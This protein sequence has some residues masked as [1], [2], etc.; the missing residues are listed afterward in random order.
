MS[1]EPTPG[2]DVHLQLRVRVEGVRVV[3]AGV[4]EDRR[5]RRAR[6]RDR[7]VRAPANRGLERLAGVVDAVAAPARV[8][9]VVGVAEEVVDRLD[10]GDAAAVGA[11]LGE[12][13]ARAVDRRR[14]RLVVVAD[15]PVERC[16][17]ELEGVR[18][19]AAVRIDE[20]LL[21]DRR[22]LRRRDE[23]VP[24][25][26]GAAGVAVEA[27]VVHAEVP[28]GRVEIAA[29]DAGPAGDRGG[30]RSGGGIARDGRLG[31]DAARRQRLAAHRE[32][33]VVGGQVDD[34]LARQD[35]NPVDELARAN[36]D[37]TA[38]RRRDV[39][40]GELV[41]GDAERIGV[42]SQVAD[43]CRG[44]RGAGA[45]PGGRG[46][47]STGLAGDE[48][49]LA[50]VVA[51]GHV[52]L[53]PEPLGGSGRRGEQDQPQGGGEGEDRRGEPAGGLRGRD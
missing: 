40:D 16:L 46:D 12:H 26:P 17:G 11:A 5:R 30:R 25:E 22:I 18:D 41:A 38:R 43:R 48:D 13:G 20:D 35:R 32:D 28:G 51:A 15:P 31:V 1:S 33:L 9:E 49:D 36:G 42:L 4:L 23:D 10:V 2:A 24:D 19:R 21:L 8:V 3:R 34:Q 47:R 7:R 44:G 37:A 39:V 14:S 27:R 53:G 29:I 50:G 52:G 6:V 45:D